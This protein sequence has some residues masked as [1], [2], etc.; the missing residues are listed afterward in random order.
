MRADE[1]LR[2]RHVLT[3]QQNHFKTASREFGEEKPSQLI[4]RLRLNRTG[5]DLCR[6]HGLN[7]DQRQLRNDQSRA[8]LAGKQ[9][10]PLAPSLGMEQLCQCACVQKVAGHLAFVPFG[11]KVG[12]ERTGDP[13][14]RLS[15]GIERETVVRQGLEFGRRCENQ[16]LFRRRI[17]HDDYADELV[18]G[19]AERLDG[20][21]DAIFE[22]GLQLPHHDEDSTGALVVPKASAISGG[23]WLKP[24]RMTI[25]PAMEPGLRGAAGEAGFGFGLSLAAMPRW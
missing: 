5:P 11:G 9:H 22:N 7:L 8:G 20:P 17:V 13:R 21:Q 1:R 23:S 6:E 10:H 15:H 14:K 19:K 2:S 16:F 12:I 3:R 24:G 25:L 4:E 18:L